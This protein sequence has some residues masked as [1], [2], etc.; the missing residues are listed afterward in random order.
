MRWLVLA[1]LLGAC[2]PTQ[3]TEPKV[4]RAAPVASESVSDASAPV[5]TAPADAA[6]P[7]IDAAP[8]C[9]PTFAAAQTSTCKYMVSPQC[10]YPEGRC[11][12]NSPAQ[13]GGAVMVTQPGMPG[14]VACMPKDKGLL[15]ID[16]CPFD[17]PTPGASCPEARACNYGE[18]SWSQTTATCAKGKWT[19]VH[20][21][22]PPPP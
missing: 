4:T 16:G 8:P 14:E 6:T 3:K 11:V 20:I 21:Q 15:R 22:S 7:A 2:A 17:V 18:C 1:C 12:C 5:A 10:D 9:P 19:V 13:C